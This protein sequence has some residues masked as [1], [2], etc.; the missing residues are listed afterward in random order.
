MGNFIHL[1]VY[2]LKSP[3]KLNGR[4]MNLKRVS[5]RNESL[6][7]RDLSILNSTLSCKHEL[8]LGSFGIETQFGF[9]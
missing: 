6:I 5:I 9:M 3:R 2:V 1:N 8:N 4:Y 7:R